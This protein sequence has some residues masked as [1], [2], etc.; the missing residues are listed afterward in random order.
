MTKWMFC[1]VLMCE[2]PGRVSAWISHAL[3]Q[4]EQE[5]SRTLKFLVLLDSRPAS[6]LHLFWLEN[7]PYRQ[8]RPQ[9]EFQAT[10]PIK[11]K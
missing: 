2:E 3:I 11:P 5:K 9:P 6:R 1:V 8:S 10:L 7:F 4:V